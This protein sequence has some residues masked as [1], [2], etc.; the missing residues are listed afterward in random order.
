[1]ST[2]MERSSILEQ[3]LV[4][5]TRLLGVIKSCLVG[6]GVGYD[7]QELISEFESN[8]PEWLAIHELTEDDF[9]T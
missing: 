9:T 3:Q 7:L 5:A 1:M 8:L 4:D 2:Q 6:A